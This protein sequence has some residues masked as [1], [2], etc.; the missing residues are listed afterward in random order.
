[1]RSPLLKANVVTIFALIAP[2]A[3]ADGGGPGPL[4]PHCTPPDSCT[5]PKNNSSCSQCCDTCALCLGCC[6]LTANPASCQQ[7][8]QTEFPDC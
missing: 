3:S 4:G 6:P 1:M 5:A 2:I 7:F 8:C